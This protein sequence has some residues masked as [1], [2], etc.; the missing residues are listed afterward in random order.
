MEAGFWHKRWENN[1]IAFHQADYNPFLVKHFGSLSL[2]AGD[3]V[4]LPLCG[5]TKDIHWLLSNGFRVVGAELNAMAVLQLFADLGIEPSIS[6]GG[7][8]HHYFADN[9][10]IFTG[11]IFKVSNQILGTIDAIYDRAALVALPADMRTQYTA[12]LT[13]I[14]NK[15]PQ[16]LIC[17]EYDQNLANGP[18]FSVNTDEV[19]QHYQDRYDLT[20]ILSEDVPGGLKGKCPAK[21]TVWLLQRAT[22]GIPLKVHQ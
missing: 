20:L 4:F 8:V 11:D 19:H 22:D 17:Y 6:A 9:I 12:H 13:K 14:T 1:E 5:K 16:L 3:R 21:E 10:D 7:D 15:A 18:P 2:M